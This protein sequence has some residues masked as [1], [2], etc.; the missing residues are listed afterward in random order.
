MKVF[1]LI[2]SVIIILNTGILGQN[3]LMYFDGDDDFV[4]LDHDIFKNLTAFTISVW[5]KPEPGGMIISNHTHGTYWESVELSN[6]WFIVNSGNGD[7]S[8]QILRFEDINDSTWHHFAGVW[9]GKTMQLYLDG[10]P[11]DTTQTATSSPWSS[12]AMIAIGARISNVQPPAVAEFK[13]YMDEFTVWRRSLIPEQIKRIMA[14]TLTSEYLY[15]CGF[16]TDCILA[17]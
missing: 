15:L 9:D 16:R 14:D 2:L 7:G 12:P 6:T 13:G 1:I 8:R 17:V 5:I 4:L 11:Y 10:Q 3:N